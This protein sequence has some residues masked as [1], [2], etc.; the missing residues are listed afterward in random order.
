MDDTGRVSILGHSGPGCTP[1]E[2]MA[3]VTKLFTADRSPLKA[4]KPKKGLWPSRHPRAPLE[5]RYGK[6]DKGVTHRADE[7][8]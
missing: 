1:H 8:L 5:A 2:P 3:L 4:K 6:H 7:L